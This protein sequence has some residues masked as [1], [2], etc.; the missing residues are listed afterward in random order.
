[1]SGVHHFTDLIIWQKAHKLFLDL[2][3][4]LDELPR[5]RSATILSDQVIRSAGSISANIAEGFQQS[6]RKFVHTLNI[7]LGETNETEN[8]LYK[9]RDAGFLA[10]D[11]TR[12]RVDTVIEIRKMLLSL[13]G[14]IE[15]HTS[16]ARESDAPYNW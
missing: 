4:D 8:W 1:M 5:K 15:A 3:T 13:R 16:S 11:A 7:A 10:Q 2:L 12:K 6:R 9:L 14:K